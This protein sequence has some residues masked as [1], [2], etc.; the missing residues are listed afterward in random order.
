MFRSVFLVADDSD[1]IATLYYI[2]MRLSS[3]GA[4]VKTISPQAFLLAVKICFCASFKVML[5][6]LYLKQKC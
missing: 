4:F 2:L 3:I 6:V 5:P 1:L